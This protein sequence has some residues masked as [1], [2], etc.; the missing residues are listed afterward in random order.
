MARTTINM[1]EIKLHKFT[2]SKFYNFLTLCWM[3]LHCKLTLLL[4]TCTGVGCCKI[5]VS[6]V[7]NHYTELLFFIKGL[8]SIKGY[9]LSYRSVDSN[10]EFPELTSPPKICNSIHTIYLINL[11]SEYNQTAKNLSSC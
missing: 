10:F 6:M 11:A 2:S 1:H 8:T 4:M 5:L 7:S 3:P 9:S